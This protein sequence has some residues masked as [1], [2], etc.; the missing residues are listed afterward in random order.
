MQF[1]EQFSNEYIYFPSSANFKRPSN[2]NFFEGLVPSPAH[3]NMSHQNSYSAVPFSWLSIQAQRPR[4]LYCTHRTKSGIQVS[5]NAGVNL[6]SDK[7]G[8]HGLFVTIL[9]LVHTMWKMSHRRFRSTKR[10]QTTDCSLFAR[11]LQW[12]ACNFPI[13]L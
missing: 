13:K 11:S 7:A 10:N 5:E 4:H 12:R 1:F 8:V 3:G 6:V 2:S 9:S